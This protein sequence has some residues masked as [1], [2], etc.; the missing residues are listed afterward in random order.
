M[1]TETSVYVPAALHN[2]DVVTVWLRKVMLCADAMQ[3]FCLMLHESRMSQE[4]FMTDIKKVLKQ[5]DMDWR[6]ILR[7][8]RGR[9][10]TEMVAATRIVDGADLACESD[11][12]HLSTGNGDASGDDA[13][14]E[15][16]MSLGTHDKPS[17]AVDTLRFGME[18]S[19]EELLGTGESDFEDLV[20]RD[21]QTAKLDTVTIMRPVEFK[22]RDKT[23]QV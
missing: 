4:S 17:F 2:E 3:R 19:R 7:D 10:Y 23:F 11:R 9:T 21:L 22:Y 6:D 5:N 16:R 14:D 18:L 20:Q 1:A 12:V 15:D 8:A 13:T